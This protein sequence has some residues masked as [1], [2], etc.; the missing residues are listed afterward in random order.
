ME[1]R[2]ISVQLR[3]SFKRRS[4][5]PCLSVWIC[6][7]DAKLIVGIPKREGF[8]NN[9]P[10]HYRLCLMGAI[11]VVVGTNL[12]N[13]GITVYVSRREFIALNLL[14][15]SQF[16]HKHRIEGML[17]IQRIRTSVRDSN[18]HASIAMS[19]TGW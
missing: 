8:F 10:A 15:R 11:V 13:G 7:I 18:Q 4:Q 16:P 5:Y 1:S 12:H 3:A 19:K 17:F 2:H 14:C 6:D 9:F